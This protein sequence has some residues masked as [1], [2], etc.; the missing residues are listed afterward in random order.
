MQKCFKDFLRYYHTSIFG[1]S[2]AEES[3]NERLPVK[4]NPRKLRGPW[5][6]GYA[7]DVH[8]IS[9]TMIGHNEYGHTVFDTV[10]SPLG[11]LLYRLKNRGDQTAIPE[12]IDTAGAFVKRLGLQV[13]AVVPVPPSNTARKHQPVIGV[14][15]ALSEYLRVPLCEHCVAKVKNTAQLKDIF[16]YTR[17]AEIL[18][19]A[20]SVDATKTKGKRLLLIDDLYRSGATVST[21][22]QLLTTTGCA[23]AVYLLTLTRTRKLV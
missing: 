3:Y 22:A 13:D 21:I 6:D 10:R 4:T 23:R 7:L 20:F 9:S 8:T 19:G 2:R 12:I 15:R 16:D 11:E 17:R 5:T 1:R 14:A 18:K